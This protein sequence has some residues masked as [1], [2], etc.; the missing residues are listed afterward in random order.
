VLLFTDGLTSGQPYA[1]EKAAALRMDGADLF[2][3]GTG[4][5]DKAFLERMAGDPERVLFAAT[6]DVAKAFRDAEEL[7]FRKSAKG[8]ASRLTLGGVL[9]RAGAWAIV[10]LV[11][12]IAQGL[13]M[14]SGKKVFHGLLGGL[15]GGLIGGALFDP[16]VMLVEAEWLSQLLGLCVLGLLIGVLIGITERLLRDAWLHVTAGPLAGKQ[17]VIYRNP[18]VFGSSPKADVYLF[19]DLRVE[20]RHAALHTTAQGYVLEDLGTRAGSWVNGKRVTKQRLRPG[21][22]VQ[23]GGYVFAYAE[24]E[25]RRVAASART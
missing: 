5:A 18:T 2:A 15:L 8:T 7:L 25:K 4:E 20:P 16:I 12:G 6:G 21:D 22:T 17:F 10:G 19:K 24:K 14:R 3:I 11:L 13:A 23:M 1:L 9:N